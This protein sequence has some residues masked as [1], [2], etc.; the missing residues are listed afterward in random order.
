MLLQL[1]SHFS[2]FGIERCS[3]VTV[4]IVKFVSLARTDPLIACLTAIGCYIKFVT[5]VFPLPFGHYYNNTSSLDAKEVIPKLRPTRGFRRLLTFVFHAIAFCRASWFLFVLHGYLKV[6]HQGMFTS[7]FCMMA[8]ID[9]TAGTAVVVWL[10]TWQHT[11]VFCWIHNSHGQ[12]NRRFSG[13]QKH[14]CECS[15]SGRDTGDNVKLLLK[16]ASSAFRTYYRRTRTTG[17]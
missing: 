3:A 6:T 17:T 1:I 7:D 13:K 2:R 12:I 16:S 10:K 14:S 9:L 5:S 15:H 8:T 11:G 4:A